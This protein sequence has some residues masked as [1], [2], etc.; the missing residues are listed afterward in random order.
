M[1]LTRDCR[2]SAKGWAKSVMLRA[3]TSRSNIVGQKITTI[4]FPR[5]QMIW[6]G[7]GSP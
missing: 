7:V 5:W 4:A 3:E 6:F 1:R 2:R